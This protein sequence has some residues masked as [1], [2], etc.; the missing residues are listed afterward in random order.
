MKLSILYGGVAAASLASAQYFP[1]APENVTKINGLDGTFISF[2][3]VS[4]WA[5]VSITV[6]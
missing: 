1:P 2:K 6:D 5:S 4:T 3:E